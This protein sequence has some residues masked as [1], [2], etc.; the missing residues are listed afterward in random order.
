MEGFPG[1]LVPGEHGFRGRLSSLIGRPTGV[2]P[3][4]S[5]V[6]TAHLDAHQGP[7]HSIHFLS[8]FIN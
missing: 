3:T 7:V 1:V 2:V 6:G 8:Q 5:H 4:L